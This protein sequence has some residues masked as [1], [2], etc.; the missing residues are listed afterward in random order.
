M[1][2]RTRIPGL[3]VP[4]L[5]FTMLAGLIGLMAFLQ[6][7]PAPAAADASTFY[8][9]CPTTEVREGE[10]VDVYNVRVTNHQHGVTFGASW[11]TDVGTAGTEDYVHQD[12]GTIWG[13]DSERLANRAKRTF[14]TREDNLVEGNETFTIRTD[15]NS[16]VDRD[17][18]ALDE[19]CEI[20]ILNLLRE[21]NQTRKDLAE[22][23]INKITDGNKTLDFNK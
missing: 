3:P 20:T 6:P 12:T 14:Q 11:H 23:A 17:D 10:S 13:K 21:E 1:K 18:P 22:T 5:A 16:I 7:A 9:D 15:A 19:K 8:L 4:V 2:K